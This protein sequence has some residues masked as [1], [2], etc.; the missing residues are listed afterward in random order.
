M[1]A[2]RVQIRNGARPIA[3]VPPDLRAEQQQLLVVNPRDIGAEVGDG[4]V[5]ASARSRCRVPGPGPGFRVRGRPIRP[6]ESEHADAILIVLFRSLA[7]EPATDSCERR[8][9]PLKNVE[10]G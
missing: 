1:H 7:A 9:K 3:R 5:E 2:N 6:W 8:Q 10:N 4:G